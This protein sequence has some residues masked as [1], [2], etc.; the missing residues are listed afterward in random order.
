MFVKIEEIE[1]IPDSLQL[2]YE[3]DNQWLFLSSDAMKCF[4][5]NEAGHQAKNCTNVES[6]SNITNTTNRTS[7]THPTTTDNTNNQSEDNNIEPPVMISTKECPTQ[8]EEASAIVDITVS[9][10]IEENSNLMPPPALPT[11]ETMDTSSSNNQVKRPLSDTSSNPNTSKRPHKNNNIDKQT[12]KNSQTNNISIDLP[13]IEKEI[14][15]NQKKYPLNYLQFTNFIEKSFGN[16]NPRMIALDFTDDLKE[17]ADMLKQIYPCLSERS[18]KN[19]FSR[20]STKLLKDED[21]KDKD[22]SS[23]SQMSDCSSNYFY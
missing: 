10:K 15:K 5:C 19:R 6:T 4:L 16:P 14:K 8:I 3:G 20:L 22:Y 1:K 13:A 9:Q 21:N 17:L 2:K 11:P 18:N 7:P 12:R 23:D